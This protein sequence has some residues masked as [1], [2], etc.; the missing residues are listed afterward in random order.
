MI[1]TVQCSTCSQLN[2][3]YMQKAGEPENDARFLSDN[4]CCSACSQLNYNYPS[5]PR[6]V[7][8]VFRLH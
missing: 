8:T 3:K 6:V 4:N 1:T 2:N 5:K 7:V